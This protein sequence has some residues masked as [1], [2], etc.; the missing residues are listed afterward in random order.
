LPPSVD[1]LDEVLAFIYTS[2]CKPT[3][4]DFERTPLLVRR[5]RVA[6]ALNWLK[7]NHIDYL[8]LEISKHNLD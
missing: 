5:N 4:S 2:P 6:I 1:E 7:D 3:M 8:D